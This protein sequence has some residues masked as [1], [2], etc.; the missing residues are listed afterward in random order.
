MTDREK[1]RGGGE[2]TKF[3]YVENEASFSDE[4]SIFHNYLTAIIW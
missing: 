4:V 2:N 3:E 1:E